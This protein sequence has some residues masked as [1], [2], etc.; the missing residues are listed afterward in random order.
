VDNVMSDM[1]DQDAGQ[2][3]AQKSSIAVTDAP[4]QTYAEDV[5]QAILEIFANTSNVGKFQIAK[6]V[7]ISQMFAQNVILGFKDKN[8][9]KSLLLFKHPI[10]NTIMEFL[11]LPQMQTQLF[12]PHSHKAIPE[13]RVF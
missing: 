3:I 2:S 11:N 5:T 12:H 8:A 6:Q 10:V 7:V 4:H 13:I 9:Q 1:Q